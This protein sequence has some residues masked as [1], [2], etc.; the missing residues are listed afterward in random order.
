MTT[1][2]DQRI[3]AMKP[4]S[5]IT[6]SGDDNIWVTVERTGNGKELRFVR[7]T[8]TTSTVFRTCRF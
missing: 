3:A 5:E 2:T 8:P 4:G 1:T 6:L 7:H